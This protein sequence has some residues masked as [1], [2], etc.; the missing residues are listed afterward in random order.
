MPLVRAAHFNCYLAVLRDI[1]VPFWNSLHRAGLPATTEEFPDLF[2]SLPRVLD[3]VIANGGA[4]SAM[5]LGFLAAQNATLESLRPDFQRAILSAPSGLA[6]LQTL[7]RYGRGEDTAVFCGIYPE[8]TSVRVVC[9]LPGFEHNPAL[10]CTE[11]LNVQAVVSIVRSVAGA[12]WI[13]EEMTFVS[14]L[15]PHDA[16]REAFPNTRML[17]AQAHTSVV[18]PRALLASPCDSIMEPE[19]GDCETPKETDGAADPL[20]T[21]REIVKPYLGD[22]PLLLSELAEIFGTSERTLQ[23]HLRNMGTSYSRLLAEARYQVA[24]DML[25]NGEMRIMEI[26]F[27]AGYQNPSHFSRAFRRYAGLSPVEYRISALGRR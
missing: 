11:W 26:A 10:I 16:A 21:I 22:K 9:E 2:L 13:P 17:T 24:C 4:S 23:R 20:D 5:E 8:G 18:V 27:A 7:M 1:G 19:T 15:A 12:A 6:R 3:C 25:K 14:G